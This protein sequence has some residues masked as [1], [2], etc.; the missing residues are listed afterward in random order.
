MS[1]PTGGSTDA[2]QLR[3]RL[4]E[5]LRQR[6][7]QAMRDFLLAAGQWQEGN[8]PA[9]LDRT[10]W[11]MIAASP[12]L[13]DLRGEAERW[14]VAHGFEQEARAILG[15]GG[16]GGTGG[17][18][19]HREARPAGHPSGKPGARGSAAGGGARD[20]QGRSGSP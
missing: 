8:I 12:A 13:A 10:M 20:R 17:P 9:D 3:R 2:R 11:M 1:E 7:P 18:A 14:L 19:A 6:S 15:R 16:A 4:D 5:V